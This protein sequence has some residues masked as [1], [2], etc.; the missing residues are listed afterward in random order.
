LDA[1]IATFWERNRASR[2]SRGIG[3][4]FVKMVNGLNF[5]QTCEDGQ[6]QKAGTMTCDPLRIVCFHL[7]ELILVYA[8]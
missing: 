8:T 4:G 3:I 1:Q 6:N 2:A 5:Q 7:V